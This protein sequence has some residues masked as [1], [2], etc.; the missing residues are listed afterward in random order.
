LINFCDIIKSEF[1][2]RKVSYEKYIN[3][4]LKQK[5]EGDYTLALL[6]NGGNVLDKIFIRKHWYANIY[7]QQVIQANEVNFILSIVG[8][9]HKNIL[10]VACGGG[11]IIVPLAQAGHRVTGFD[12]DEYMLEKIPDKANG[13]SNISFYKA[14]AVMQDWGKDFDV[15]ILAGNILLNIES[16]MPYEQAQELFIKKAAAS[17][18]QNGYMY[19]DFDCYERPEQTSAIKEEWVCFDGTDDL[20]T[21]GKYVVISGDYSNQTHIDRSYRRYEIT[22]KDGETFLFETTSVK[23]FPTFNQVKKWLDNAGWKIEQLYGGYQK[24][25]FDEKTIGNRAIIW[26]KKSSSNITV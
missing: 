20:G 17:V 10:E 22:P 7:E 23:H 6:Q 13:L 18:K 8:N 14:D 2:E 16:E 1:Y 11:R 15:V 5:K 4:E 9:E 26:A 19:L 25:P 21:Y 3:S 12:F 24:N